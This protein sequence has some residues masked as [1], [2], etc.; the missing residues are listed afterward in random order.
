MHD[1]IPVESREPIVGFA[2]LRLILTLLALVAVAIFPVPH[3]V[4]LLV[5]VA[6]AGLPWAAGV[7]V[8]SNRGAPFAFSPFVAAGDVALLAGAELIS[9]DTYA[10]VRFL[11]L[12]LVAGHAQLQGEE[13]GLAIAALT[14]VVLVPIGVLEP[15]SFAG[16][17]IGFY[18]TFFVLSAFA[19][20]LFAGRL[21]TSESAGRLRQRELSRR[22]IEAENEMRRRL[23]ESIPD[24]PVHELVSLDMML[25]AVRS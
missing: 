12:F 16:D 7:F 25:S 1:R 5:F 6:A 14:V 4:T 20:G 11:A 17:L 9:P 22:A 24:G 13:R 23:A 19:V 8:T 15:H 18:E 3:K 21:R 2:V 10:A